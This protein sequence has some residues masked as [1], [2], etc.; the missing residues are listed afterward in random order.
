MEIALI[1]LADSARACNRYM[2]GGKKDQVSR[3]V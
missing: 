1:R 2:R 3:M